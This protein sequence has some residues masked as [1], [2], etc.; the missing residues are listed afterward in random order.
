MPCFFFFFLI[1]DLN[2]PAVIAK[3][4][5]PIAEPVIPV[6]ISTEEAKPETETHPVIVEAKIR[7]CSI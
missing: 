2:F 5:N 7:N 1:I 3:S 4:F 6:G